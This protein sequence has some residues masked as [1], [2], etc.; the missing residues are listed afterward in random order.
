MGDSTK[1]GKIVAS[2]NNIPTAYS[3]GAGSMI[4]SGLSGASELTITSSCEAPIVGNYSHP[5]DTTAPTDADIEFHL[6]AAPT[7][8]SVG[9][10]ITDAAIGAA[11]FLRSDSGA[12]I[13]AGT[14][15][16]DTK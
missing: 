3:T 5:S 15:R 4:V 6:P 1:Y 10:V 14:V 2:S 13:T 12:A 9:R 8:Q 7:G 11:I 16:I